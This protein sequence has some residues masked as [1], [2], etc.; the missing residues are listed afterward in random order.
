MRNVKMLWRRLRNLDTLRIR[1]VLVGT[2][3][4]DTPHSVRNALFKGVYEEHE[5]DIVERIVRPGDCVLE[6]GAGIGLISLLAMRL[7]L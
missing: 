2:R 3:K 6:I 7:A 5:C 4:A 1:G